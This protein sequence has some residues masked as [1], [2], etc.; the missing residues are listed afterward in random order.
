MISGFKKSNNEK[1]GFAKY[2]K[3]LSIS[4][5]FIVVLLALTVITNFSSQNREMSSAHIQSNQQNSNNLNPFS[6]KDKDIIASQNGSP[7]NPFAKDA[8]DI[9]SQTINFSENQQPQL[10]D[11]NPS[12]NLPSNND[13]EIIAKKQMPINNGKIVTITVDNSVRSN[14]FLPTPGAIS[15]GSLSY[16]MP[17]PETLPTDSDANKVMSTTISGILYDKY[18]PSAIINIA[19]TDYLV[20]RG[21][22]IN[23]YKVLFIDKTQVIVQLGKNIYKAGVGELLSQTDINYNTIANLNKKFGG[24]VPI[25]VKKSY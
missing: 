11:K 2:K 25:N 22:I 14:P 15:G 13:I 1:K 24:N 19:G 18:S 21:D 3:S 7:D 23:H 12:T 10:K 16:L 5:I 8:N 4:A 20:K 17:P 9:Y 6:F